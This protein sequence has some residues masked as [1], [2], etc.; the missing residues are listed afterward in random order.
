[1][2]FFKKDDGSEDIYNTLVSKDD[3][4]AALVHAFLQLDEETNTYVNV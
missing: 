1:M 3:R 4:K 2:S